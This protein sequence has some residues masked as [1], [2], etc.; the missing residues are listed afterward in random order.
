[1]ESINRQQIVGEME[2]QNR[3][4]PADELE[5]LVSIYLFLVLLSVQ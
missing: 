2:Y 5:I 3:Q 4:Q 1:M